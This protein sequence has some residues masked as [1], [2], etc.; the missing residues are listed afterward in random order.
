MSGR[1]VTR[2][3]VAQLLELDEGFL[4]ELERNELVVPDRDGLYDRTAF[5]R[6]RICA[7]MHYALGVNFEGVEVVLHLLER[8]QDERRRLRETI[9]RLREELERG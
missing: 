6:A 3:E 1:R 4:A 9:E 8:W 5:E 2:I 7:T